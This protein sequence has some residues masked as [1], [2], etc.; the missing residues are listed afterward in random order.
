MGREAHAL[1]GRY[2]LAH[3]SCFDNE[4]TLGAIKYII[5]KLKPAGL[6]AALRSKGGMMHGN[7]QH[8]ARCPLILKFARTATLTGERLE[9]M[10]SSATSAAADI[11]S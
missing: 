9:M 6:K 4:V 10:Q 11:Y 7:D 5:G 1:G 2:V 3:A 8:S